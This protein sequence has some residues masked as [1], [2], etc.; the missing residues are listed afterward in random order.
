MSW[1]CLPC[2]LSHS[3]FVSRLMILTKDY[4]LETRRLS[5]I[6]TYIDG[7]Y[8]T[9]FPRN[10]VEL[11]W[12]NLMVGCTESFMREIQIFRLHFAHTYTIIY[13]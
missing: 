8:Y 13:V 3:I 2:C 5:Y 12:G 10:D 7:A 4:R 1:V 11:T 6:H 9:I